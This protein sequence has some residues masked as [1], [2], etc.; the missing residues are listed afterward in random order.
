MSES[1]DE[2]PQAR[3]FLEE[4]NALHAVLA[5]A[6]VAAWREPTQFKA[7]TFD[8]IVGHLYL[9]DVVAEIAARSR[10]EFESFYG[11][12]VASAK[13]GVSLREYAQRWLAGCGGRELLERWQ[14]QYL[15]LAGIA[16]TFEP[17]RRLA[18]A[19]P[20]MSARSFM[21]AR[22]ME[23]WSH[24]Q[25]I[26]DQLGIERAEHDRLRNVAVMGVNTFGWTFTV[27]RRPLPQSKPYVRLLSPSGATWE[28]NDP[29]AADRVEGSAVEFCQV[30][31]QTRNVRDTAL[32]VTG[33]VAGEWMSMAQCFAGPPEQPPA[34]GTR[35]RRR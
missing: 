31:T 7:W 10:A 29:Q 3:D 1:G 5:A 17:D 26:F 35:Y 4:C 2:L 24:G 11:G 34:P 12:I 20:D 32:R 13:Q 8:D 33:P 19:G 16:R 21:S 22:Q 28:F 18:W 27:H 6:P 14:A 30:V 9:F 15:R 25:A 23:V